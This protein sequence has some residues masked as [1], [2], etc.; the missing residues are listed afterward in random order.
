MNVE[1]FNIIE[2][3]ESYNLVLLKLQIFLNLDYKTLHTARQV[4][5]DWNEFILYEIWK[6]R[7]PH[8]LAMLQKSWK[9]GHHSTSEINCRSDVGFYLALDDKTIGLGTKKNRTLLIDASTHEHM[10][11][12][13]NDTA[14]E[15]EHVIDE[16]VFND[17]QLDMTEDIIVTVTGGGI[18]TV[19]DRETLERIYSGLPHGPESIL[20]VRVIGDFIVTGGCSGSIASYS[21][22]AN[23][24]K[25]SHKSKFRVNCDWF[26]NNLHDALN[27]MDSDGT[28]VLVG[29]ESEMVLW[30][31]S[32]RSD[33]KRETSVKC[34]QVCCCV[35]SYPHVFCTGLFINYGVQVWNIQTGVKIRHIHSNLS[36][37]VITI[38]NNFLAT[39][40]SV[41]TNFH[42]DNNREPSIF[43]HDLQE[44]VK[45]PVKNEKLW[46][47]ELKCQIE[48]NSDPHI[49]MNSTS[50]FAVSKCC[51]SQSKINVWKFWNYD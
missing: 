7:K 39:S 24:E 4:C 46:T 38:K 23:H 20:G 27:H 3:F 11:A 2:A 33:P 1:N 6:N 13:T 50:L 25:I 21:L 29:T 47:R 51:N 36:M 35:M 41:M 9:D 43:I 15:N 18:V 34:G 48:H 40:M 28:R 37:W 14:P 26:G 19:W 22:L 31:F 49:A 32:V 10:E 45:P 30:D 5:K 8:V 42:E 12:L 16:S 17:V 44:L